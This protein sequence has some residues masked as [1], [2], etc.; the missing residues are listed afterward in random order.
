METE[1]ISPIE[2]RKRIWDY[3]RKHETFTSIELKASLEESTIKPLKKESV[4]SNFLKELVL[5][6]YLI[7]EKQGVTVRYYVTL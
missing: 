3:T 6:G 2:L 1:K 7:S 4:I 5:Y